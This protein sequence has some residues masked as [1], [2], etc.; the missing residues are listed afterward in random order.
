[1]SFPTATVC[2]FD[3][4]YYSSRVSES[5]DSRRGTNPWRPVYRICSFK[6]LLRIEEFSTQKSTSFA[7]HECLMSNTGDLVLFGGK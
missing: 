1:M 2:D 3:T 5:A 4:S 7:R 6:K